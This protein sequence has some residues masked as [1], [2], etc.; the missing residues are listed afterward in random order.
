[1]AYGVLHFIIQHNPHRLNQKI[2]HDNQ[3]DISDELLNKMRGVY[4]KI[5]K[6]KLMLKSHF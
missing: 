5:S 2:K 6:A 1:M 3:T 4:T